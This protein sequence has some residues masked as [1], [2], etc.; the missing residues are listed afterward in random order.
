MT[1]QLT[2]IPAIV[3]PRDIFGEPML[4]IPAFREPAPRLELMDERGSAGR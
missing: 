2:A 3:C 1:G 4:S